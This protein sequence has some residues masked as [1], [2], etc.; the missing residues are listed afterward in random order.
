MNG[1]AVQSIHA[2]LKSNPVTDIS[3]S[4]TGLPMVVEPEQR[5][6]AFDLRVK[7]LLPNAVSKSLEN[8]ILVCETETGEIAIL[9]LEAYAKTEQVLAVESQ[10]VKRFGKLADVRVYPVTTVELLSISK[11]QS[12]ELDAER[13]TLSTYEQALETT[14]AYA[15][16]NKASDITLNI[17]KGKVASQVSFKIEGRQIKP[18]DWKLDTARLEEIVNVAWQEV[19]GGSD[20]FFN[21]EVDSQGVYTIDVGQRKFKLRFQSI[22]EDGGPSVTLRLLEQNALRSLPELGYSKTHLQLLKRYKGARNGLIGISGKVDSGKTTAITAL[23]ATLPDYYKTYMVEDPIEIFLPN[24]HQITM[25]RPLDGSGDVNYAR[26]LLALKR[27]APDAISL[28][29]IRDRLNG[30]ALAD[31]G[32]MGTLGFFTLHTSGMLLI[33]QK[34]WADSISVPRDFLSA[35]GSLKLLGH[36]ALVPKLCTCAHDISHLV[37]HGGIDQDGD[38]QEGGYWKDY[39]DLIEDSFKISSKGMKVR[40]H[41]GCDKCKRPYFDDLNGYSG[42]QPIAEMFEPNKHY[43]FLRLISEGNT[44]GMFEFFNSLQRESIYHEDMTNKN[45]V[46]CGLYKAL[47]GELDPRDIELATEPFESLVRQPRYA[48]A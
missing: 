17:E 32:G 43:E 9:A 34:L 37:K 35:P 29:E 31:I 40:K 12:A 36:Q 10:L 46:E 44:L 24:V 38:D 47:Q 6:S 22:S 1:I 26:K 13:K 3:V 16:E 33:P 8:K 25:A 15:I 19:T 21:S 41:E 27:V 28:G 23:I 14:V 39:L 5:V 4:A 42:R 45:I 11:G 30:L 18:K 48:G 7:R 20:S 2:M